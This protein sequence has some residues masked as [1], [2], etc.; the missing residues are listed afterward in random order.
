MTSLQPIEE[1]DSSDQ[2]IPKVGDIVDVLWYTS[3]GPHW[4]R[5]NLLERC[6]GKAHFRFNISYFDGD[7]EQQDLNDNYWRFSNSVH[8]FEPG[9]VDELQREETENAYKVKSLGSFKGSAI[10]KKSRPKRNTPLAAKRGKRINETT[11]NTSL[12]ELEV[13]NETHGLKTKYSEVDSSLKNDESVKEDSSLTPTVQS[14]ISVDNFSYA[15]LETAVEEVMG[16][17]DNLELCLPIRKRNHFK[18]L[19]LEL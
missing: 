5:G 11:P 2:Q 9:D 17:K 14:F 19:W 12:L 1:I 7:F 4:Y 8:I 6:S 3:E 13:E 15:S 10:S 16:S 18:L